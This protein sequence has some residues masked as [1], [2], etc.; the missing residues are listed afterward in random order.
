[1]SSGSTYSKQALVHILLW[2]WFLCIF[3]NFWFF[4][5]DHGFQQI[6]HCD[7]DFPIAVIFTTLWSSWKK[8]NIGICTISLLIHSIHV[9]TAWSKT[10]LQDAEE[11]WHDCLHL[12]ALA[13]RWRR[14]GAEHNNTFFRFSSPRCSRKSLQMCNACHIY[15]EI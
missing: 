13:H 11:C 15:T 9:T 4:F 1:M 12:P 6:K 7:F 8:W 10:H 14:F 3:A 5:L 2:L